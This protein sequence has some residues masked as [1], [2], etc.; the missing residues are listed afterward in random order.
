MGV[1]IVWD[2]RRSQWDDDRGRRLDDPSQVVEEPLLDVVDEARV[3]R[4][5]VLKLHDIRAGLNPCTRTYQICVVSIDHPQEHT[6]I[7]LVLILVK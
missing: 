6:H 7:F 4:L 1:W 3:I 5:V 2:E